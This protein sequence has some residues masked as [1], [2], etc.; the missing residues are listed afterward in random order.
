M[1]AKGGGLGV[2][3]GIIDIVIGI[4]LIASFAGM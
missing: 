4:A 3:V 1:N 2:V